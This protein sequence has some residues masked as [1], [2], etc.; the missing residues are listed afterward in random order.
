MKYYWRRLGSFVIDNSVGG[1]FAKVV[2]F[3]INPLAFWTNS[4]IIIDML[5]LYSTLLLTVF[6]VVGYN[7]LAYHYFKYPL[8]KLLMRVEVANKNGQRLTTKEY[9]NREFSKYILVYAT[10]GLYN[11]FQFLVNVINN[12]QTYHDRIVDSHVYC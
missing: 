1:M 8:G 7:V 5:L 6:V 12:K 9:Y 2:M 3:F 11:I 10:F 4:N